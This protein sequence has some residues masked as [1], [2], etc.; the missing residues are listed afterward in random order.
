MKGEYEKAYRLIIFSLCAYFERRTKMSRYSVIT[1]NDGDN[2][3]TR[4]EQIS[5]IIKDI[6]PDIFGLQEV[7]EIHAPVYAENLGIYDYVYYD[8]D[9]TTYNSQPLYFKRDKFELLEDGIKW[10]SD[11]PSVRSKLE[12]SAYTRSFTYA[13]LRDKETGEMFVAV[14]SH[15][16]YMGAANV[17]QVELIVDMT[18]AMFPDTAIFYIADWNMRPESAGYAKMGEKGCAAVETFLPD[19]DMCGTEVG[20]GI[21]KTIDFCFVDKKYWRGAAYKVIRDHKYSDTASDHYPV[22][23]EIER[24]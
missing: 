16:D 17:K 22:Y 4:P 3:T 10:I 8:N 9:G 6:S 21:T 7:Q 1:Y 18:R 24:I 19:A 2:R 23:V 15:I 5:E 14:N 20:E 12:E 11:T 13:K